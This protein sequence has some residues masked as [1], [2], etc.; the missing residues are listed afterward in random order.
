M[1][2]DNW[3]NSQLTVRLS[4]DL[5]V[6][7]APMNL[8]IAKLP[9]FKS[10]EFQNS[11]VLLINPGNCNFYR[12]CL[13]QVKGIIDAAIRESGA[14]RL[15]F[16]GS[17]MGA[18]GA[19]YFG[20][21]FN[22]TKYIIAYAPFLR[23]NN[24][25]TLSHLSMDPGLLG[26]EEYFYSEL[27]TNLKNSD[28][29]IYLFHPCIDRQDGAHIADAEFLSTY[30]H[31]KRIHLMCEHDL[32]RHV[33]LPKVVVSLLEHGII[34][35]EFGEIYASDV[36]ISAS[37]MAYRIYADE[38]Q[39]KRSEFDFPLM[40]TEET[41]SWIYYYWK[42][43]NLALHGRHWASLS[44]FMAAMGYGGNNVSELHF[45]VAN[46]LKELNLTHAATGYYQEAFKLNPHNL[47]AAKNICN[48]LIK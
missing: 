26:E 19:L 24:P 21:V 13:T 23:L 42:A 25:G 14:R 16:C 12:D 36:E 9:H 43:R 11:S 41:R 10:S 2:S 15:A 34:P 33:S 44:N 40:P 20:S 28:A 29:E 35:D 17:S 18:Y 37:K 3:V 45:C 1:N 46:V 47:E 22:Q 6:A 5:I 32:H 31:V 7:L 48:L 27:L 8:D 38:F 30:P 39:G 4:N